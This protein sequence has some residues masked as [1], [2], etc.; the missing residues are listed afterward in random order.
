QFG[1]MPRP[2]PRPAPDASP[3]G[4]RKVSPLAITLGVLAVLVILLVIASEVWTKYLWMDQLEYTDVLMTRWLTQGL[5]FLG[6]F[7]V[8][9]VPLFLSLRLAYTKRPVYPPIT[10]EQ[11]ALEQF[12]A[13][14]DPLRRGLTYGAP[15]I[16][17]AFGGLALSRGWKDVQLFL[18]PQD[19]GQV[20]PIFENDISFYVFT[21]PLIDM[22]ISFGQFVLLVSIVGAV[23]GHFIY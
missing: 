22:L 16:I 23:I 5:L 11:E 6:G 14:V 13:A 17:G 1:D 18:H 3:G 12:R 4:P 9:A 20:D 15:L 8:F 10:R 19:F 2:R 21:L 7:V